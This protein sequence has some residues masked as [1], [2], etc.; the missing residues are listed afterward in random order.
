MKITVFNGSPRGNQGNTHAIVR[1]FLAGATEA[2]AEVES[3]FLKEFEIRHCIACYSCWVKTPGRCVH[4]DD[5]NRL[6][7]KL[8]SSDVVGFASPVYVDNVTGLM[9]AFIDRLITIGSPFM[10]KDNNGECRH[11]SRHDKPTRMLVFSNCGFP[12]QSHFQVLR[13]FFRR[14]ARNLHCQ[15]AG[16]IYR[17]SGGLITSE[18]PEL[19]AVAEQ[20]LA[21]VKAAGMEFVQH[22]SIPEATAIRLDRVLFPHAD[23]VDSF[24]VKA[25]ER[26][27]A[28]I[29]KN[30]SQN[31]N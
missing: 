7:D 5:G 23:F 16:E 8:L 21:Q 14:M 27:K 13:L 10:E 12:E 19:K 29:E 31:S 18:Q 25:N 26:W 1:A 6:L 11:L 4:E 24:I 30:R 22:G 15:L 9:K 2:G 3:V 17:G 28:I 20:Y